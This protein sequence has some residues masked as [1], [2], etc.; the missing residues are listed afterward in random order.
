MCEFCENIPNLA[1]YEKVVCDGRVKLVTYKNISFTL[2]IDGK[3]GLFI[4]FCPMC[5]RE[6][7]HS[8][9]AE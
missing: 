1:R 8:D 4:K 7:S 2:T 9:H 5:G 6:L 3:E